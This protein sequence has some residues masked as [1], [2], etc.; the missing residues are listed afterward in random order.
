[1]SQRTFPP[2]VQV[3]FTLAFRDTNAVYLGVVASQQAG[4]PDGELRV[5]VR[6]QLLADGERAT[7]FSVTVPVEELRKVGS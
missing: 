2:G 7:A 3:E 5:F 1:M 6:R 4:V